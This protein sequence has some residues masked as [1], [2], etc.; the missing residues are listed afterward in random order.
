MTYDHDGLEEVVV[1][2]A[3]L[4]EGS[5]RHMDSVAAEPFHGLGMLGHKQRTMVEVVGE[6]EAS[7]WFGVRTQLV[8]THIHKGC[9][10]VEGMAVGNGI[11]MVVV[12]G[13]G[14][15]GNQDWHCYRLTQTDYL[16]TLTER[17]H[18]EVDDLMGGGNHPLVQQ[19]PLAWLVAS[20]NCQDA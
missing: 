5:V 9:I 16:P 3:Y 6:A 17:S 2:E 7:S 19:Q 15:A 11:H 20:S 4:V 18:A 1:G 12:D 14:H 10:V 13:S 8:D